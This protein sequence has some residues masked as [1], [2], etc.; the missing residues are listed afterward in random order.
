MRLVDWNEHSLL[1]M[2]KDKLVQAMRYGVVKL[3]RRTS[4]LRRVR[5]Y[6][7]RLDMQMQSI[8]SSDALAIFG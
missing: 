2:T 8:R 3:A 4:E 1:Y 5:A 7:Q 6:E